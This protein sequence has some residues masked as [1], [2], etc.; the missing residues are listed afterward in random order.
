MTAREGHSKRKHAPGPGTL[1]NLF[2]VLLRHHVVRYSMCS[3]MNATASSWCINLP[4]GASRQTLSGSD[5]Q[6]WDKVTLHH[7]TCVC[8]LNFPRR[9]SSCCRFPSLGQLWSYCFLCRDRG[10]VWWGNTGIHY[11]S[12]S[13][14]AGVTGS[15]K[16]GQKRS[17]SLR[18]AGVCGDG[19]GSCMWGG[20]ASAVVVERVAG[21][22][23]SAGWQMQSRDSH[24]TVA[25]RLAQNCWAELHEGPRRMSPGSRA[26][27]LK[28]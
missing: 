10:S 21:W 28:N 17:K 9:T 24:W 27:K 25:L 5:G 12:L 7:S 3:D 8:V 22:A 14:T 23:A 13:G 2:E 26:C 4:A 18:Q 19:E 6:L 16:K 11:K 15:I 20:R 1:E